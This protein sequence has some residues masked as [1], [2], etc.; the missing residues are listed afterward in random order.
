M[1]DD[2]TVGRASWPEVRDRLV[3]QL[4]ERDEEI[5]RLREALER[6]ASLDSNEPPG[7]FPDETALSPPIGLSSDEVFGYSQI[8]AREAL[9]QSPSSMNKA[10]NA[11][12]EEK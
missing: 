12:Q 10:I 6:I 9:T 1:S 3:R 4:Q 2:I 8:I 11:G 5:A 7:S